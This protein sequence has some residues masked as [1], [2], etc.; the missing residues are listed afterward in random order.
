MIDRQDQPPDEIADGRGD[1]ISE[2]SASVQEMGN[3][4]SHSSH[5]GFTGPRSPKAFKSSSIVRQPPPFLFLRGC[6]IW[7]R[8]VALGVAQDEQPFPWVWRTQGARRYNRP[9][10]IVPDRGQGPENSSK[11]ARKQPWY[12]LHDDVI[13]SK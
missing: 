10:R 12:V 7:P 11:P 13:G 3:P 6:F 5:V 2:A 1:G 9:L 4:I 8:R